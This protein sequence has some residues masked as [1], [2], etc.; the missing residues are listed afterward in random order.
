MEY[1]VRQG[2]SYRAKIEL[3]WTKRAFATERIVADRLLDAGFINVTVKAEGGGV[4]WAW[5]EWPGFDATSEV[6]YVTRLDEL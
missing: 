6:D 1:T 5:G 4:Y 3:P 2:K